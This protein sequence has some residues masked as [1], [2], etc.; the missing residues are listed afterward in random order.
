M[1]S[2]RNTFGHEN[3][4][5]FCEVSKTYVAAPGTGVHQVDPASSGWNVL[6]PCGAASTGVAGVA[7]PA[8]VTVKLRVADHAPW[9]SALSTAWTRQKKVPLG[10]PLTTSRVDGL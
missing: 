2:L 8:P 7:A 5:S 10:R 6:Y 3:V 4:G 9:L 1:L